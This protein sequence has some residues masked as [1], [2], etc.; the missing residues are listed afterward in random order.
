MHGNRKGPENKG[1]QTGRGLGFCTSN[2]APGYL[3]EDSPR[4]GLGRGRGRGHR[5]RGMGQGAG[6]RRRRYQGRDFVKGNQ[7]VSINKE[8]QI[9]SSL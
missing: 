4:L 6:S 3:N 9:D 7:G 8:E 5:G 2:D 1:S